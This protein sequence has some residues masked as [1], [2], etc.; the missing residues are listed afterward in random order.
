MSVRPKGEQPVDV[1]GQVEL[2]LPVLARHLGEAVEQVVAVE[3]LAEDGSAV[4]QEE[5]A[6]LDIEGDRMEHPI[7]HDLDEELVEARFEGGR[8][9][10]APS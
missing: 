9:E 3:L 5:P 10:R 1:R 6:G 7:G 4:R 8:R 2:H